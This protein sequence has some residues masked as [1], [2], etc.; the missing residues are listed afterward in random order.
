M[1]LEWSVALELQAAGR[2][3]LAPLL[4][5]RPRPDGS[6]GLLEAGARR[7]GAQSRAGAHP[8][9]GARQ[10]ADV[11]LPE[12]VSH[13]TLLEL[14]VLAERLG[15]ELSREAST[16]TVRGVVEALAQADDA[17]QWAELSR[18]G[19]Y[20]VAAVR[21]AEARRAAAEDAGMAADEATAEAPGSSLV[22]ERV[23]AHWLFEQE[24]PPSAPPR[25][26][27]RRAGRVTSAAPE[28]TLEERL[29]ATL[30]RHR[31]QELQRQ[32]LLGAGGAADLD[33]SGKLRACADR[34]EQLARTAT[35][36]ANSADRLR[37]R[38]AGAGAASGS[39]G[40]SRSLDEL[41][42]QA[43]DRSGMDALLASARL[44][45]AEHT[46]ALEKA[47][48][49]CDRQG[50]EVVDDLI[51]GGVD[52]SQDALLWEDFLSALALPSELLT[53]RIR[54]A[55]LEM[56]ADLVDAAVGGRKVDEAKGAKRRRALC[57]VQ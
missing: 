48:R 13:A 38:H 37:S 22:F 10:G 25:T 14:H 42:R 24:L 7:V 21:D 1:L 8:G 30:D 34:L 27:S 40:P 17:T 52:L 57:V 5:G 54:R 4:V 50:V 51:G 15:F 29:A 16:R 45:P 31:Q 33:M 18:E 44:A 9:A 46:R 43:G 41:L 47:W 28:S 55:L 26:A 3:S 20:S 19:L 35:R 2:L 12:Q 23:C 39:D 56:R 49:W 6:I 11:W 32:R 36:L 53:N